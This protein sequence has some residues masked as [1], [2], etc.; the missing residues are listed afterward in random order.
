MISFFFPENWI[1]R[2]RIANEFMMPSIHIHK[3]KFI[4]E[5]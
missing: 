2:E 4:Y 5:G 1:K 3:K